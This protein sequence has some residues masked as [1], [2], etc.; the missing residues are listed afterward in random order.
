MARRVEPTGDPH[1]GRLEV[2]GNP[3]AAPSADFREVSADRLADD[4]AF[5]LRRACYRREKWITRLAWTNAV[6]A[7]IM[8]FPAVGSLVVEALATLRAIGADIAPS[9]DLPPAGG[10]FGMLTLFNNATFSLCIA[11]W[12][13]LRALQPWARWT[14]VGLGSLVWFMVLVAACWVGLG[15]APL[16]SPLAVFLYAFLLLVSVGLYVLLSS[17]TEEIFTREY[18]DAVARTRWIR[19]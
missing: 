15:G 19:F 5:A 14:M 1:L 4:G 9:F 16:F 13:G 10:S 18:R 11:L 12:F 2:D 3:Y 17:P 7:L 6:G 8:L